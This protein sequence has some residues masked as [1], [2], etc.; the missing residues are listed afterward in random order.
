MLLTGRPYTVHTWASVSTCRKRAR[1]LTGRGVAYVYS[2][3]RVVRAVVCKHHA[4][5]VLHTCSSGV[6]AVVVNMALVF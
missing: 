5:T 4:C 6:R 3:T 1:V 2:S